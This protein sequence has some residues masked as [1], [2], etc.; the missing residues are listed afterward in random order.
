MSCGRPV[1]RALSQPKIR[2]C[3]AHPRP[4]S[5]PPRFAFVSRR[6]SFPNLLRLCRFR[7]NSAAGD[8]LE[9]MQR[10]LRGLERVPERT[11]T[12][13]GCL[14]SGLPLQRDGSPA[15]GHAGNGGLSKTT[16]S[17]RQLSTNVLMNEKGC[18]KSAKTTFEILKTVEEEQ[19]ITALC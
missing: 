15:G 9:R 6:S 14:S 4:P 1:S 11:A 18:K 8:G 12:P 3:L 2:P 17:R 13:A 5:C 10:G 7:L 16:E 19:I